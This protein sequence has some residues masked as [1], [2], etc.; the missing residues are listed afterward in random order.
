M[1]ETKPAASGAAKPNPATGGANWLSVI[2][3]PF[4]KAWKLL[5]K[6]WLSY[7]TGYVLRDKNRIYSVKFVWYGDSVYLHPMIWGSLLLSL[8]ARNQ[9]VEPQWLLLT[10]FATLFVCY[11]AIM[12]NF[13]VLRMA[14]LGIGLV[15]LFGMAYVS[16]VEWS[17]NP[18]HAL[19]QHLSA[20]KATVSA[21]FYV[22]ASYVFLLLIASEVIWAWLFHRVEIDESYVYEHRFL[23]SSTRE[24]IFAR[25][26]VRET[27][28]LLELLLLGAADI[29]HRTKNGYKRFKNVP[30]ASL[31]LGSA[32][33]GLL[34]YRR[35]GQVRL[36]S[37]DRTAEEARISDALHEEDE[38]H[39]DDDGGM[40]DDDMPDDDG[41]DDDDNHM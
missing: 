1:S 9:W 25:G 3:W 31:W 8:M 21:G 19:A 15:A 27:K 18:L 4:A 41:A 34:D 28:D 33:D 6:H 16:T 7:M 11:L 26:L 38:G 14:T 2:M 37:K 22:V 10:W 5:H 30:F 40:L 29:R 36:E 12:Y 23:S 35:P 24:P 20:Q 32:I 39:E 17:W 13:N